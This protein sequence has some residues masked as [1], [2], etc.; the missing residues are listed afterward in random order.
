MGHEL[1]AV[2]GDALRR[3]V[4]LDPK[5]DQLDAPEFLLEHRRGEIIVAAMLNAFLDIWEARIADLGNIEDAQGREMKDRSVV[6]EAGA[7]V[8]DH[9]LTMAIRA[10]D[11]CPPVDLS[12]SDF[13]SALLTID[14]E[15]VPDDDRYGYRAALLAQFGRFKIRPAV[16]AGADGTWPRWADCPQRL[17]Y[18]RTHFDSL[19]RD[20]QEVFR[21]LWENREALGID[22]RGYIEIESVRPAMRIAPDGFALRETIAEYVQM[23]TLSAKELREIGIAVPEPIED[24]ERIRVYGGGTLVFD[25]Y[26][27][28]KYHIERPLAK[29][30]ADLDRQTA[31]LEHLWRKGQLDAPE[32]SSAQIA[33]LHLARAGLQGGTNASI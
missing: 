27:Q 20:R 10:I 8:A 31:R 2:R 23:L 3:S 15:V 11:Y 30:A 19:L 28:L 29:T 33:D 25:D 32:D 17:T 7:R 6:V 24:K 12:F 26:G 4:M 22:S 21:F 14:S 1:S 13:L 16:G 5:K 18:A 9:L